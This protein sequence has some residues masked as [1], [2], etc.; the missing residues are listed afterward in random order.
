MRSLD[1]FRSAVELGGL[2]LGL[3]LGLGCAEIR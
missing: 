3:G 1:T 2:G